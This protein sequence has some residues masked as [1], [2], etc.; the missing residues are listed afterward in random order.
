M[1]DVLAATTLSTATD[2]RP[3]SADTVDAHIATPLT[4]ARAQLAEA[5]GLLGYTVPGIVT[6]KPISLV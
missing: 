2:A 3:G 5:I 6:G 1:T 4:D